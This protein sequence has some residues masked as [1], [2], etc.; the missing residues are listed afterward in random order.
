MKW[1]SWVIVALGV[2]LVLAPWILGF[3]AF[4]LAAWNS[5]LMGVLAIIFSFWNLS[6]P[7]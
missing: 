7:Q 3:S 2:W 4:N 6:E 5:V 1:N